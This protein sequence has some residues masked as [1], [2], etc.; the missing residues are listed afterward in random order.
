MNPSDDLRN[1]ASMALA[2]LREGWAP[3]IYPYV[4]RGGP[5]QEPEIYNALVAEM[6]GPLE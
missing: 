5:E 1:Y 3:E 2:R 4:R 6:Y